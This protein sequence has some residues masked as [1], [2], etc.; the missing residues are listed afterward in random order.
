MFLRMLTVLL[1]A[2][3]MLSSSAESTVHAFNVEDSIG[4][5]TFARHPG[6]SD[7]NEILVSPNHRFALFVTSRGILTSNQVESSLWMVRMSD[8][9]RYLKS[10][11][12][13]WFR[14]SLL[15]RTYATPRKGADDSRMP[16]ISHVQ[17]SDDSSTVAFL[18][19]YRGGAS[20]LY[21]VDIP[22]R[23]VRLRS[24]RNT[25]VTDYALA[26][27]QIVF[28]TVPVSK[29]H[30]ETTVGP[31]DVTGLS[32]PDILF[33]GSDLAFAT[34]LHRATLWR[35]PI[36]GAG[37]PVT[38]STSSDT[39]PD[40]N[41]MIHV[42]SVSPDAHSVIRALPSPHLDPSWSTYD[43]VPGRPR[44][45]VLP[46]DS[47]MI[48]PSNRYRLRRYVITELRT[49]KSKVMIDA[50]IG[51]AYGDSDA[52]AAVWAANGRRILLGNVAMPIHDT[53]EAAG[54][55]R[56]RVCAVASVDYPSLRVACIV[57]TRDASLGAT[58]QL[59]I[60]RWTVAA[61]SF[62]DSN[63]RVNLL[64][65]GLDGLKVEHYGVIHGQ[66][67]R[68]STGE[69]SGSSLERGVDPQHQSVSMFVHDGLNDPPELWAKNLREGISK[70]LWNPNT[71]I[72]SLP[73]AREFRWVDESGY[74]WNGVLMMPSEAP[75][76]GKYPLVIQTHGVSASHFLIDG[77]YPTAE[78][79]RALAA[80]GFV[81]LQMPYRTDHADTM[82]E[83]LDQIE[84]YESAVAALAQSANVDPHRVGIVAF[85]HTGFHVGNVLVLRP[86]LFVAAVIAD[87]SDIGYM[88]YRIFGQGDTLVSSATEQIMGTK[89]DGDGMD[90]WVKN[91]PD[92]HAGKVRAKVL[93]QAIGPES[94]LLEW[95]LYSSL[96]QAGAVANM[97]Y[98]PEGQHL[99]QAPKEVYASQQSTVAWFSKW[100]LAN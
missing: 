35:I 54:K 46:D 13:G 5:T 36:A 45:R 14:P 96:R 97:L 8:V 52:F 94:V 33:P 27:G 99:L 55:S 2:V 81:V 38:V 25:N 30:R 9:D 11:G 83:A 50:P 73:Q 23:Q 92:F 56:R 12:N 90:I 41:P 32:L 16:V 65:N 82:Q 22:L 74:K 68:L 28:A 98:I 51:L 71:N 79:A 24:N 64:F 18:A 3:A 70:R 34:D 67:V 7:D 85:S 72:G 47:R 80:K 62:G 91:S 53:S 40:R 44:F 75:A 31:H 20:R 49:G 100:L 77:K 1:L 86:D 66:W 63:D 21:T 76:H 78:A 43:S 29:L 59:H 61:V 93:I 39:L 95:E 84:G 4:L 42:F 89:P 60:Q 10:D 87:A 58:A 26:G 17:W 69:T 57:D 15:T 19:E 37:D 88:P 48:S 6:N